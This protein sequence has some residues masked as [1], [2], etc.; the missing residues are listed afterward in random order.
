M[1]AARSR[2]SAA[3]SRPV[4][5]LM[6]EVEEIPGVA[7]VADAGSMRLDLEQELP[8]RALRSA[9]RATAA[10]DYAIARA[11]LAATEQKLSA[12]LRRDLTRLSGWSVISRRLAAED[13]LLLSAETSLRGRF[14]A[15]DARYIDV[16]R[17]RTE[18]LRVQSERASAITEIQAAR[19]AIM[20]L[21]GFDNDTQIKTEIDTV[22][23]ASRILELRALPIVDSLLNSSP[24]VQLSRARLDRANAQRRLTIAEQGRRISASLGAQRF[25]IE[26][27]GYSLGPAVAFTTTLPF[28]A[29]RA[30]RARTQAAD[31]D[32]RA[33]QA[34]ERHVLAS[35]RARVS[36]ASQR[37]ESA[38]K[39]IS[40]YETALLRGARDERE[41]ALASFRSGELS[42]IELLDFERA[43]SRAEIDRVK[44]RIE[45]ADALADLFSA[46]AS[47]DTESRNGQ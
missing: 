20:G 10:S 4:A 44:A 28:T 6:G 25:Q 43:L 30:N 21:L 41:S 26:T 35:T 18:R 22:E 11:S 46:L 14:A 39:R 32:L 27:G 40:V 3:G 19:I 7:N 37:Y 15:G 5:M 1:E 23:A 47:D 8:S 33:Q 12:Q 38:R 42:L 31:L 34:E 13:A 9:Q 2:V 24:M 17:L 36:I 16:L 45:A 29:G